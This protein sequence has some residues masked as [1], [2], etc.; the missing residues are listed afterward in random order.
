MRTSVFFTILACLCS[1][2]SAQTISTSFAR[3][4][5]FVSRSFAPTTLSDNGFTATFSGGFQ[6]QSFDGPAYNAGP[7]SVRRYDGI[8][9]YAETQHYVRKVL[10]FYRS[11]EAAE[12]Y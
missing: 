8:P 7:G 4:E 11:F 10:S 1:V 3:S 2:A 12:A 9:P 5:G 6:E